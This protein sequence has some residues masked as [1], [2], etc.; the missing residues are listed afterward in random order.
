L[1]AKL[2]LEKGIS[3]SILETLFDNT[4]HTS[5]GIFCS[6]PSSLSTNLTNTTFA[7][8]LFCSRPSSLPISYTYTSQCLIRMS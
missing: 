7:F 3:Y 4:I 5:A 8:A 6:P 1:N 2:F